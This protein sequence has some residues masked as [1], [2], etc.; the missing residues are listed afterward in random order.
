ML[1]RGCFRGLRRRNF[2]P[3]QLRSAAD[4]PERF[5]FGAFDLSRVGAAPALEVE[6]LADRVVENTHGR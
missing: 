4:W 3:G 1:R 5:A 6:M 2:V